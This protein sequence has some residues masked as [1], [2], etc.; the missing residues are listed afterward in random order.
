[1]L[2][3]KN[4]ESLIGYRIIGETLS[5]PW[6]VVD[7]ITEVV[8]QSGGN[9]EEYYVIKMQREDNNETKWIKLNRKM[10]PDSRYYQLSCGKQDGTGINRIFVLKET[11]ENRVKLVNAIGAII[12]M[13]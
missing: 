12:R 13:K 6:W 7:D 4:K 1:M 10:E 2:T 3:I 11:L 8:K 5:S 9:E